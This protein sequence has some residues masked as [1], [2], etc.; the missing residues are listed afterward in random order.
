M[1]PPE[2]LNEKTCPEKKKKKHSESIDIQ[3]RTNGC[4]ATLTCDKHKKNNEKSVS[5]FCFDSVNPTQT[6]WNATI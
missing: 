1:V 4:D 6:I 5:V 3:Y 2:D